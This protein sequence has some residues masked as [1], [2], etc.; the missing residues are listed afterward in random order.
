MDFETHRGQVSFISPQ[1]HARNR[2]I[3]DLYAQRKGARAVIWVCPGGDTQFFA[4]ELRRT[5]VPRTS[6][7]K[8]HKDS[9]NAEIVT[10]SLVTHRLLFP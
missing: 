3:H 2:L 6:V 8:G 4:C 9:G 1:D 5:S 10:D 7:N